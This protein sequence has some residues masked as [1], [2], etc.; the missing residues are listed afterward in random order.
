MRRPAQVRLL[1]RAYLLFE[2]LFT[3]RDRL[4]ALLGRGR[5]RPRPGARLGL[6]AM[7]ARLVPDGR[8]LP[9][10]VLFLG[11]G[12]GPPPIVRGVDAVT[13]DTTFTRTVFD[14][15]FTGGVRVAAGDFNSD[16]YPDIVAG[17]GPGGGPVVTLLDGKSGAPIRT[18]FAFDPGF[19]GG[20]TVAAVDVT[21]DGVPDIVAAAGA[22]GGPEVAVFDG[23]TGAL[24]ES[25]FAF[26]PAFTGGVTIAAATNLTGDGHP[27]LVVGAGVGG[28]PRVRVFDLTTGTPVAGPLGSFFAFDPATRSGVT[29]G[30]DT[31]AGD[32]T[33]DGIPD[34]VVGTGPGVA[35]EVKVFSGADGSVVRDFAPFGPGM[36]AGVTVATAYVDDDPNADVIVGTGPG[37]PAEVKIFSGATGQLVALPTADFRPFG[38]DATGGVNLAASNDPPVPAVTFGVTPANPT[39]GQAVT[40]SGSV[41]STQAMASVGLSADWGDGTGPVTTGFAQ[42]WTSSTAVS[43]VAPKHVYSSAGSYTVT[44]TATASYAGASGGSGGGSATGTATSL[45]TVTGTGASGGSGGTAAV[46]VSPG[47][48]AVAEGG[49]GDV[50]VYRSGG[51]TTQPLTVNLG[52][53]ADGTGDPLAAWNTDYTLTAGSGGSVSLG[54]SGGTVTFGAYQ[55]GVFLTVAAR[56][57]AFV[58][59]TEGFR[60]TVQL[61]TGYTPGSGGAGGSTTA[62]VRL[63]DVPPVALTAAPSPAAA[64]QPVTLTATIGPVTAGVAAPTGAVT[65]ADAGVVLGT[66]VLGVSGTAVVATLTTTALG[67]GTHTLTAAYGGDGTY[68]PSTS[69]PLTETVS[70]AA[71]TTTVTP[72]ANPAAYG[73]PVTYTAAVTGPAGGGTPTGSVTF[74]VDGVN[75]VAVGLDAGGH[76]TWTPTTPPGVGSHTITASYGGSSSFG[77]SSGSV[78]ETVNSASTTTG[79][80]TPGAPAVYGRAVTFTAA[81]TPGGPGLGTPTGTVTFAD[82]S[83]VLGTAT[84]SNGTATL[85]TAALGA[86]PHTVT[87]TYGGDATFAGSSGS[88]GQVVA[89][90]ALTVTASP[91]AMT[92]ADGTTLNGAT[93][94]TV[95]GL[96]GADR[97]G[98]VGL[99]TDAALSTSGNWAA[100]AAWTITP[101]GATGTGLS[102][103]TITYRPGTLTVAPKGLTVTGFAAADKTYDGTTAA[104]VTADGALAGVVPGDAVGLD[105]AGRSAAFADPHAGPG[106]P[107]T[108]AG[109]ALAG[110]DARD[111]ALA[112]PTTTATISPAGTTTGLTPAP[113]PAVFGQPVTL[114]ATVGVVAPG[115]GTPTGTVT[116]ADGAAV[117][118]TAPLTAGVAT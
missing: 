8:P 96:V 59:G 21:G 37:I 39:A 109:D 14:P 5:R 60:V 82:G 33:G 57:D 2:T 29:V 90:A 65:F 41:T 54:G 42:T 78:G 83:S 75:Q 18:F 17:A 104:G 84:L 6:E 11:T 32:V 62:D 15:A 3:L 51:D 92:Y 86:G 13:G 30:T 43:F 112:Q 117:L 47:S 107:V 53:G 31:L 97:V 69:P 1:P 80:S 87:A 100:G 7:E 40:A 81:V 66:G 27:D 85:T 64:G 16:G 98:A 105:P 48:L 45:V 26:D 106:K 24:V 10:P 95:A 101:A 91:V 34:L 25:F 50:W 23:R 72:S 12:Q 38:A 79:V 88:A 93:G 94:F 68:N 61:G 52:L 4:T 77:S 76:A 71:T 108:A 114:T 99:S 28:G 115:A 110:A 113:T 63:T 55:T 19:T 116:F 44:V 58:E 20:V 67:V 102:N 46:W 9:L 49:S 56:T 22:G 70:P 118:G 74:A 35:S 111:Y 73:Q 103:Y 36:T 89:P